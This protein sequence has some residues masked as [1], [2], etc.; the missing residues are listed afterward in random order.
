M[1][2]F[3]KLLV[4]LPIVVIVTV[5]AIANRELVQVTVDPF[6]WFEVPPLGVPLFLILFL[7]VA[8]GVILGGAAVW[9]GQGRHRRAARLNAKVAARQ[10]AELDR[11]ATGTTANAL[12]APSTIR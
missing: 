3:L 12:T 6:G 5:F 10:K 11:M 9:V 4:L 7:S 1:K 2:S 8:V